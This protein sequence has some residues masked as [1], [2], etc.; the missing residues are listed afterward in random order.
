MSPGLEIFEDGEQILI[1]SA[2]VELCTSYGATEA[3]DWVNLTIL[4]AYG[5]NA[6]DGVLRGFCINHWRKGWVEIMEDGC[7]SRGR[8]EASSH[9]GD[10]THGAS[11][12]VSRV[13]VGR[14]YRS[15]RQ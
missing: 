8:F 3:R 14:L 7:R 6:G 9:C 10:Q 4:S 5:G 12:R 1:V 15:T 13:R 11:L 2:V